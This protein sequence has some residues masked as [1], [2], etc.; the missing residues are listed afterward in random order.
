[1]TTGAMK[2]RRQNP[3]QRQARPLSKAKWP[4]QLLPGVLQGGLHAI[5][6]RNRHSVSLDLASRIR[7]QHANANPVK[8]QQ[9]LLAKYLPSDPSHLC[10]TAVRKRRIGYLAAASFIPLIELAQRHL[11]LQS[12]TL[13]PVADFLLQRRQQIERYIR[14]LKIL[15][16]R[17]RYV[18]HE[19][20]KRR[21]SR[22]RN[23]FPA[24]HQRRCIHPRHQPRRNRFHVALNSA[25]LSGE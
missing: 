16:L 22:R 1:M 15:A 10:L 5:N 20:A 23:R 14:R 13:F 18:V 3:N 25:D 24:A 7:S 9:K 2:L 4:E 21:C 8:T 17:P 12:M 19:R 11:A 6:G